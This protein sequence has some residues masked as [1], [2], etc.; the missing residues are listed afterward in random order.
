MV[1]IEVPRIA[2]IL[3]RLQAHVFNAGKV[4]LPLMLDGKHQQ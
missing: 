2:G 3:L 1:L 4:F